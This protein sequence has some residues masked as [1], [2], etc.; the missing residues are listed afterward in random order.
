METIEK[1][2]IRCFLLGIAFVLVWFLCC[3]T[4]D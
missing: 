3:V 1:L 2:T 4:G